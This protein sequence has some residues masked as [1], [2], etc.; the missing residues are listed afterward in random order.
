MRTKF[1]LLLIA[2]VAAVGSVWGQAANEIDY[3]FKEASPSNPLSAP[4][5]YKILTPADGTTNG[6]VEATRDRTTVTNTNIS[7]NVSSI[8]FP[9]TVTDNGH[10]YDVVTI[11]LNLFYGSVSLADVTIGA[12]VVEIKES[13]FRETSISEIHIPEGVKKLDEAAFYLCHSLET[14]TLG[15]GSNLVLR[16][17]ILYSVGCKTL[18]IYPLAAGRTSYTLPTELESLGISFPTGIEE[19]VV[20]NGNQFFKSNDGVLFS[21]DEKTLIK[22][23]SGRMDVSYTVPPTV[24]VIDQRAFQFAELKEINFSN[25]TRINTAAFHT[26]SIA[27]TL[28]IPETVTVVEDFLFINCEYLTEVIF[29]GK[30]E[31]RSNSGANPHAIGLFQGCALLER[32][33]LGSAVFNELPSSMFG[34]CVALKEVI[35]PG[36][37]SI[38]SG[39]FGNLP[40]LESLNILGETPP[41]VD[42]LAF[43]GTTDITNITLHVPKGSGDNY[44]VS[45]WNQMTIVDDFYLVLYKN[46]GVTYLTE[47]YPITSDYRLTKPTSPT[48]TGHT[49]EGWYDANGKVVPFDATEYGVHNTITARWAAIPLPVIPTYTITIEP[50]AG[51]SVNKSGGTVNEGRPFSFT[52]EAAAGYAVIVY[53]NGTEH[54]PAS[55]NFYLIE[56]I[57]EDKTVTFKLTA[58]NGTTGGDKIVI[59]GDTPSV[60]DGD[61][62]PSG[63]IVV[64]PPVVTFPETPTVTI[65]GEEV[66]G[67]W[68]TDEDG[69][70]IYVIDYEGLEDGKHTLV[71]GDKT[72]TFTTSKNAVATSNDVLSTATVTAGYGTVT[73]DTPK[74]STVYVVSLSGS[75][76][77]NAKVVGTVTVNVP[78]GIYV[79]VVDGVS[80]KIVVR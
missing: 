68:T 6:T 37:S 20:A 30:T 50:L 19:I 24:E 2:F 79:V 25:V 52:A 66:P 77:Y 53:V 45:P 42:A 59:D 28:I 75:V 31:L 36:I 62:P 39:R 1:Y 21:S 15:P 4:L 46:E 61:Y 63:E 5:H 51:V 33:D 35:I 29:E 60:I 16:D 7:Y 34:R 8:V 80:T 38:A 70:P 13:A 11:G 14:I 58:G 41:T 32:V 22:Y 56:G 57:T 64:Y 47:T 55:D 65:D 71:I 9:A 17:G 48:R 67:T 10:D 72:Y 26:S 40:S 78:S 44:D 76:V 43:S 18:L 23:P 54:A 49:F 27:G 12:K 73:I 74:S 69:K 3:V